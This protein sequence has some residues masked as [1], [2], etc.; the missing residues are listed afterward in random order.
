M[1]GIEIVSCLR[2]SDDSVFTVTFGSGE[3]LD[4]TAEEAFEYGLYREGERIDDLE[5]FCTVILAKRMMAFVA[6]YVLF[7]MK[8]VNQVR[9]RLGEYFDKK[10]Q[11]EAWKIYSESAIEEAIKRLKELDYINDDVYALRYIN[12]A[13]K[14]KPVSKA[15]LFN[16]LVYKKGVDKDVAERA[17][18]EVCNEQ[19]DFSDSEN[20]YRLLKKK[21]GGRV[22]KE[23]DSDSKK[24]YLKLIRFAMSKGFSYS[25][26]ENALRRINEENSI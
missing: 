17:I 2:S 14:G 23:S 24:E 1:M 11:E 8:T 21:T 9:V 5:S 20:A 7:S 15:A 18:E 6:S 4:F 13:L 25:D 12:T 26:A 19:A 16:E 22:L 3:I 10:E